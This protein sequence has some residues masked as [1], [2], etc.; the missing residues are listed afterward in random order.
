MS[1]LDLKNIDVAVSPAE[2]YREFLATKGLRMT[3]ERSIIVEEVFSNHEHFDADQLI[4]RLV[5][6]RDGTRV[7][8]STIYRSITLLEEAGLIRKVA[9]QDGRDLYEHDYGYPQHD[10]LICNRC[11]ELTEFHNDGISEILDQISR[12]YGFRMDGHRLE[13]TGLCRNCCR[14]PV[15]RPK[16][17]NLL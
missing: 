15:T 10:H 1:D 3:P 6:R 5:R 16:K 7:S 13:V 8:R 12:E 11:G 4:Q 2:K 17:L 14:A 9:R